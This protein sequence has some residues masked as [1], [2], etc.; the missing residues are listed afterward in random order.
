MIIFVSHKKQKEHL[1]KKK[2][3]MKLTQSHLSQWTELNPRGVS[4]SPSLQFTLQRLFSSF[5]LPKR[6]SLVHT[7]TLQAH[8]TVDRATLTHPLMWKALS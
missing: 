2:S 6:S 8:P 4:P 7:V 1:K 5:A 3:V